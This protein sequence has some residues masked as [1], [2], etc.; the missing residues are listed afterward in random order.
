MN[1]TSHEGQSFELVADL[2]LT[3][4]DGVP[5]ISID[6]YSGGLMFPTINGKSVRAVIDLAGLETPSQRLPILKHHDTQREVGH[7]ESVVNNGRTLIATGIA[8]GSGPDT[9]QVVEAHKKKFPWKA[10]VGVQILEAQQIGAGESVR[11]NGR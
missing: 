3:A 9:A 10:S 1:P 8:S 6:A 7:T 2:V 5:T 11:V 4:G